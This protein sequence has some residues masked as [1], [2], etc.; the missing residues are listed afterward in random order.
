M[1]DVV[2]LDTLDF[3]REK[4]NLIPICP[5]R[6]FFVKG[7][8]LSERQLKERIK[9]TARYEAENNSGLYLDERTVYY[10]Y[11]ARSID[12]VMFSLGV[13]IR[14]E[15]FESQEKTKASGNRT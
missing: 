6:I 2:L 12:Q 15:G 7:D 10:A 5:P 3:D 1:K 14:R 8:N 11:D 13:Y 9:E 4:D